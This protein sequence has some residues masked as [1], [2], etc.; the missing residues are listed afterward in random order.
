MITEYR[1]KV[2]LPSINYHNYPCYT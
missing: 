1:L 2:I